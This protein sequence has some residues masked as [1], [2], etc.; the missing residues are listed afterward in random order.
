MTENTVPSRYESSLA[1]WYGYGYL[2]ESQILRKERTLMNA[3]ATT[4]RTI[5]LGNGLQVTIDERGDA[6]EAA[7]SAVLL[8]HGGAGPRTFAGL[9]AAL[10]D[11]AYVGTPTHP[12]LDGTPS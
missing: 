5:T 12:G 4:A 1:S 3:T 2:R 6:A 8:L 10:S 9:G 11:H 7:G